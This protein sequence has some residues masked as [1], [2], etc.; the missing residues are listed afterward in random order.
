MNAP[1]PPKRTSEESDPFQGEQLSWIE[2]EIVRLEE[3]LGGLESSRLLRLL[4]RTSRAF[5][6]YK[7]RAGQI[8][9]HSPLHPAYLW[10]RGSR[11]AAGPD[12]QYRTW[13]EAVEARMPTLVEHRAEAARFR[14][15]PVVS[16]VTSTYRPRREFLSRT[17]ASVK[18][19]SYPKW[20]LCVY[21]D[22]SGNDWLG[23]YLREESRK[24]PRIRTA[25]G[26]RNLGISGGLN[27]ACG[28]AT[29]EYLAFL[30]H[31]D[32]LHPYA[33]HYMVQA[34]Q[35]GGVDLVYSDEDYLDPRGLR[36]GPTFKPG[37]SPE[38][39]ESCMYVGH[40]MMA[41]RE[42]VSQVGGF[43]AA[44]D[45]AQDYDLTMRVAEQARKVR[46]V[47][48]VL[49]HWRQHPESTSMNP[50]SK[51]YAHQA[52]KRA[53]AAAIE[54]RRLDASVEDGPLLYTFSIRRRQANARISLVVCSRSGRM[55]RRF[56][57]GQQRT[58]YPDVD[59]VV[60]EHLRG[61]RAAHDSLL[62]ST[63]GIA[64]VPFE[65]DFNLAA[66]N[67]L[68]ARHS[69]SG[70]L[71]FLHDDVRPLCDDWL[72]ILAGHLERNEIGVA[73]GHLR[74]P[75]GTL[76][77]A[78]QVWG[79]GSGIGHCGRGLLRTPLMYYLALPRDVSGVS[80]ACLGIRRDV[81]EEAG[82]FDHKNFPVHYGDFDLCQRVRALGYRVIV[83]PRVELQ[84]E[85]GA[86]L[87]RGPS[88]A[89]RRP[90]GRRWGATSLGA[91]GDPYYSRAFDRR[92]EEIRL[93]DPAQY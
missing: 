69:R 76:Q 33:L 91:Q 85:E 3:R 77:D 63:S 40:L 58:A 38:L 92:N 60:V 52:G 30:D 84:H 27:Q 12:V 51:P 41:R 22:G 46:H 47:P 67:N 64:R 2:Q 78:G 6:A 23:D 53:V 71:V 49:Y 21:D 15:Q 82:A 72:R 54:R 20:Q 86:S 87:T 43:R 11:Y 88:F 28:L 90:L 25:F 37:W 55:L 68:G 62:E 48:R 42:L 59:V 4:R 44:Y 61:G 79:L 93:G 36:A 24:D 29:G 18:A 56:L 45:G 19:Q 83:D 7:K 1:L 39:L 81:F 17:I 8:L 89:D 80:D 65:G 74:Y 13:I 16:I 32:E 35:E 66:M 75:W 70:T 34:C 73:G 10:L 9:L 31:D 50:D 57:K 26:E 14:N 5:H